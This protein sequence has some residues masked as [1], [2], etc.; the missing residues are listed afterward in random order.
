MKKSTKVKLVVSS[1]CV[2][3]S[4]TVVLWKQYRNREERDFC[5]SR[6]RM[7]TLQFT[8]SD[9]WLKL[10]DNCITGKPGVRWGE[11]VVW[12]PGQHRERKQCSCSWGWHAWRHYCVFPIPALRK[13]TEVE[14]GM[15]ILGE[16][17]EVE[18]KTGGHVGVK[19]GDVV[20]VGRK[21]WL[22][23]QMM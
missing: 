13:S 23:W 7:M 21:G 3:V 19:S 10:E 20:D 2:L 6:M 14:E 17:W 12:W 1:V 11:T 4:S 5:A 18:G 22:I 8:V 16:F 15:Q 9:N